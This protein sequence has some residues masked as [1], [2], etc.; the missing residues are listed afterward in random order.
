MTLNITNDIELLALA[1]S[2]HFKS[3][4]VIVLVAGTGSIAMRFQ[5]EGDAFRRVAR[6]GGWGA[7]LGDDG[8]GFDI[9][10]KAIRAALEQME[11]Q[12]YS[13]GISTDTL[14]PLVDVIRR[15]FQPVDAESSHI[16]LLNDVLLSASGAEQSV[17]QTKQKIAGCAKVVVDACATS[18]RAES[19]VFDAVD[20]LVCLV[21]TVSKTADSGA[22]KPLLTLAG[23]LMSSDLV[24]RH[25]ANRLEKDSRGFSSIEHMHDTASIGAQFLAEKAWHLGGHA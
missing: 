11:E 16:S 14:D 6:A 23:G 12:A 3:D 20:S 5:R 2:H 21:R 25:L 9:G 1:S 10:R 8:S 7:L 24:R 22:S 17:S 15:H 18:R 19:I 13:N 4:D